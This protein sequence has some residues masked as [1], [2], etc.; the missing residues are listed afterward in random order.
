MNKSIP[1]FSNSWQCCVVEFLMIQQIVPVTLGADAI[2][3]FISEF[4]GSNYII[5]GGNITQSL[6]FPNFVEISEKLFSLKMTA[7]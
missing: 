1:N 3:H 5:F 4:N 2:S 7:T 6:L